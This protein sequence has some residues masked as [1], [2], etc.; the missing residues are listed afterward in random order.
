MSLRSLKNNIIRNLMKMIHFGVENGICALRFNQ[1]ILKLWSSS[2]SR[3]HLF[4]IK[5]A[6]KI[7]RTKMICWNITN[8]ENLTSKTIKSSFSQKC[9]TSSSLTTNYSY[10][11]G[12]EQL[13]CSTNHFFPENSFFIIL[14]S[15]LTS[16]WNL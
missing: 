4:C 12:C 2:P 11:H 7:L 15:F 9:E 10:E 6:R 8:F 3:T 1:V 14:I 5:K 13:I 16:F